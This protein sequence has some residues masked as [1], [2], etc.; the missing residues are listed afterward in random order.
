MRFYFLLLCLTLVA[1]F[2]NLRST[3]ATLQAQEIT[4]VA[5]LD[6]QVIFKKFPNQSNEQQRIEQ[7]KTE[8]KSEM[9]RLKEQLLELQKEFTRAQEENKNGQARRLQNEMKKLREYGRKYVESQN[10]A[11]SSL[12]EQARYSVDNNNNHMQQMLADVIAQVAREQGY[13][14]IMDKNSKNIIW[15]DV[16]IDITE[17]VVQKLNK[18]LSNE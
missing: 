3:T 7:L 12:Q 9:E 8:T 14:I 10:Q 18:R 11:I 17:A 13:S 2:L 6:Y 16:S 15:L 1:F 5:V 4:R